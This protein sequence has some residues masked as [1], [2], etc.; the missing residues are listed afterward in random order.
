LAIS[1]LVVTLPKREH[2]K[3]LKLAF[4]LLCRLLKLGFSVMSWCVAMSV[5]LK[6]H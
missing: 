4:E 3:Y 6:N 2:D 5:T 1:L